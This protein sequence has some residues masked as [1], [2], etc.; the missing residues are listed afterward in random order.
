[1]FLAR[2]IGWVAVSAAISGTAAAQTTARVSVDSSGAQVSGGC[3]WASLS[4]DGRYVAFQ[5]LSASLVANDQN[6]LYDAFVHDRVTGITERVSVDSSGAE[7]DGNS[8]RP[9]L[10]ADGR[11]VAFVSNATNLD[12]N[13]QYRQADVFVRDRLNGTTELVSLGTFGNQADDASGPPAISADGRFVAFECLAK[14]L[15]PTDLNGNWDIYVRDRTN[16]TTERVSVDT[17]GGEGDGPSRTA[18]LSADGS[19]VAFQSDAT[20][21]VGGDLNGK[22]DVF[23]HDRGSG[24]TVRVSVDSSGAEANDESRDPALSGDGR[25][26][27]FDSYA[28]N[29]VAGDTNGAFDVFVHDRS[30]LVTERASVRTSGVQGNDHSMLPALNGDGSHVAFTSRATNLVNGDSNLMAD[31]F[32]RDRA[33][34]RTERAS[35]DSS[36]AEGDADSFYA[37]ISANG[38]YVALDSRATNLVAGNTN[39]STDIF[40][41]ARPGFASWSIYGA[42]HPGSYGIPAFFASSDP[43]LGSSLVLAIANSQ[44]AATFGVLFLGTQR[45]S[46]P[47]SFGSDLLVQPLFAYGLALP[48]VGFNLNGAVPADPRL[49]GVTVDL[50]VLEADQGATRGVSFTPGLELVLGN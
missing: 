10:S 4:A 15:D 25:I 39:L 19:I 12:P 24:L 21:L 6:Q 37:S 18:A 26:V 31:V 2:R 16:G 13:D 22:T 1:M 33:N 40:V 42:G 3:A 28:T 11:F 46:I 7:S 14:N 8:Y 27:A 30:T 9:V 20:N 43:V 17:S 48:S 50:Q 38:H 41:H 29:L 45:A 23:T 35:V 44:G 5:S 47:T 36:G 32:V 34:A 49:V